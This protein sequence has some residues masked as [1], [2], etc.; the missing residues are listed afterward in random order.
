MRLF[1]IVMTEPKLVMFASLL[2][3]HGLLGV[4]CIRSA[5]AYRREGWISGVLLGLFMSLFGFGGLIYLFIV[6]TWSIF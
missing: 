3:V 2:I 4:A 6:G 5:V 1:R